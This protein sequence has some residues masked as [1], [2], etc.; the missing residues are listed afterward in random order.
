[1]RSSDL[2]A[3][4]L[5]A[6]RR[7]KLRTALTLLG[8]VIGTATLVI[9][10]S[11]GEG[12]RKTIDEEFKKEGDL[13]SITVFPSNDGRDE[14][15]YE[16]VPAEVLDVKGEM[17]EAKRERIRKLAVQR[18]KRRHLQP[19]PKPL[20]RE[21]VAELAALPHV[22]EVVPELDELGRAAF[23]GRSSDAMIYGVPFD[24]T[25]FRHR[26]EVG[27]GFSAAG[28][29]ECIVHE[30]LLYRWGV[31]DDAA[32]RAALGQPVL[33][34]ITNSR[35]S[36]LNILGLFGADAGNVSQEELQVLEKV[37]RML[38]S[39]LD[40]L[41][42]E[43]REKEVLK[44]A[45]ARKGPGARR[46]P[47]VAAALGLGALAPRRETFA[48]T[49]T[50]V[51]VV[52]APVKDDPP[53][54]GFLDGPLLGAD[55]ILPQAAAEEFFMKLP[56][57]QENGYTRVRVIVDHEDNLEKVD[58]DIKRLGLHEFS[59]GIFVRQLRR[60]VM[61]VGFTMDF[62]ALVAIIVA[63]LGIT[64]TMFTTVLERTR[65]I[66]ILKAI[67]AKD[68]EVLLIFLIEGGLIGLL[69]GLGGVLVGWL[70]SFPGNQY[71]LRLMAEQGHK[72][73]PETVFL[74]PMWLLLS[75][76]LFAMLITTLAAMLPARRAARVEPVIA[77]RHE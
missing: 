42:L 31:R 20:T 69:G 50:I 67:G 1:V 74:Y 68:R 39:A 66:G 59:M 30:F 51:G 23:A 4:G 41:P 3:F 2:I 26:L 24:Y 17:S 47:A 29:K 65:E 72:E 54:R 12:V 76:P 36:P 16:G 64:N 45:L 33:V 9:S 58:A 15:A 48:E 14:E 44:A 63:A 11:I 34:Q 61:L 28:A 43:P 7:Q 46:P 62:I 60:N 75:V 71:A 55:V 8:V 21:R 10:I 77:L 35:R 73:L 22:V 38:P 70:A 18:W 56:R 13:R 27:S 52:R 25:R 53:D 5:S 6:L 40:R 32:V 57:R 37:W 19:A 49:F